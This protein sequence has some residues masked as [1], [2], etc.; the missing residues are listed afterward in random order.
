GVLPARQNF[1]EAGVRGRPLFWRRRFSY[2]Y[3][4][5][6][7]LAGVFSLSPRLAENGGGIPPFDHFS[8]TTFR[9]RGHENGPLSRPVFVRYYCTSALER[10]TFSRATISLAVVFCTKPR[11]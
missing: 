11:S 1:I 3:V 6:S 5:S 2:G 10:G 9:R 8:L 7:T 4:Y